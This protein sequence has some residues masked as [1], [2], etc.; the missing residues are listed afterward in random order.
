ML[1]YLV[2]HLVAL[3]T[4]LKDSLPDIFEVVRLG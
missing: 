1:D 2:V 3:H 4:R